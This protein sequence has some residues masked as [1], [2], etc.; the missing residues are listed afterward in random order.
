[1]IIINIRIIF[2]RLLIKQLI[3]RYCDKITNYEKQKIILFKH[4]E[5]DMYYT[6]LK[7]SFRRGEGFFFLISMRF[8]NLKSDSF[9][10]NREWNTLSWTHVVFSWVNN[11]PVYN[12]IR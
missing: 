2:S 12:P 11:A 1:M 7:L 9:I 8:P 10:I 4:I 5:V 6:T 3:N